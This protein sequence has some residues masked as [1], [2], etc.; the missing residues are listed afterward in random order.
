MRAKLS[1]EFERKAKADNPDRT[2]FWDEKLTG[3]GLM[4]TATGHKSYVFTYRASGT[5][6][7]MTLDGKFLRYEAERGKKNGGK[8][9][10][11]LPGETL[12]AIAR[13]EARAVQG[14]IAQGR[15]PLGELKAE[16]NAGR[17]SLKAVAEEFFRRDGKTLRSADESKADLERYVYNRLGSRAID[18][19]KRSEIVRLLDKVE[20]DHGAYAAQHAL[21]IMRRVMNWWATRDD[22]FLSPMVR[23]MSRITTKQ[24]ARDRILDDEELRL[25]WRVANEHRGPYDFLMQFLLLTAARLSEASDMQRNELSPDV[26]AWTVP[27]ER[28]KTKIAHVVPLSKAARA[29]LAK[30]PAIAGSA[31]VFTTN[32]KVAISGFSKFKAAF[33]ARV[34]EANGDKAVPRWTPH[35]L[36]RTARSLMSRAGVNADHAERCLGHVIGGVRGVYDRHAFLDEK[37][38]AFE[39][40]AALIERIIQPPSETVVPLRKRK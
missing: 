36:R 28:Y 29:L 40:L 17:N 8:Y 30:V 4:V 6:R 12:F 22:D 10:P 5:Q 27:G 2:F 20:D 32:G 14:A 33:D 24:A 34:T 19:I 39:A 9:E 3:F 16:R 7:R 23:G 31:F 25:V 37:R 35:D 21:A 1:V 11:P 18:S 38:H 15:D 13:R 26:T